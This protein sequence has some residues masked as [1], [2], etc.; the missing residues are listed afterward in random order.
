MDGA[1]NAVCVT[2]ILET[3]RGKTMRKP[4][5]LE[6]HSIDNPVRVK[7]LTKGRQLTKL[8]LT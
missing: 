6:I 5:F 7:T 4:Y 3:L 2:Y 8:R 1:A